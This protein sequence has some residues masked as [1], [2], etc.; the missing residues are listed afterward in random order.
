MAWTGPAKWDSYANL[1]R[2]ES[3]RNFDPA[4]FVIA[5]GDSVCFGSSVK[6]DPVRRNISARAARATGPA[7]STG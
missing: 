6:E 5:V 7:G 1:R 3:M 4:F 2:L